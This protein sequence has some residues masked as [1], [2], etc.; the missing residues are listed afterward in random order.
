MIPNAQKFSV[1]F[2]FALLLTSKVVSMDMVGSEIEN[3]GKESE[4]IVT[5]ARPCSKDG[6]FRTLVVCHSLTAGA[7]TFGS[8][9]SG[10]K[11]IS[12]DLTVTGSIN[13]TVTSSGTIDGDLTVGGRSISDRLYFIGRLAISYHA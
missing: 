13:G 6:N 2:A 11:L 8:L 5:R 1:A 3:L 4:E 10:N 7:A 9:T 12:G